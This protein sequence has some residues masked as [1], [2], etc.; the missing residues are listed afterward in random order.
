MDAVQALGFTLEPLRGLT[1]EQACV[2]LEELKKGAR[3]QYRRLVFQHHPDR[4]PDDPTAS[5]TL[6]ELGLAMK[7]IEGL[8]LQQRQQPVF[9]VQ[10]AMVPVRAVVRTA[11]SYSTSPAPPPRTYDARRVVFKV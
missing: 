2:K 8:R 5:R 1:F 11:P 7:Q 4:N 3:T 9:Q 6:Q 10:F